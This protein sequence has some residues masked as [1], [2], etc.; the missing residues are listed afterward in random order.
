[1]TKKIAEI[2]KEIC[3]YIYIKYAFIC[4]QYTKICWKYETN[5]ANICKDMD[6]ICRNVQKHRNMPKNIEICKNVYEIQKYANICMKSA[7]YAVSLQNSK[8]YAERI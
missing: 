4:K 5:N 7:L 6:A 1:M 8:K 3:R 2:Y